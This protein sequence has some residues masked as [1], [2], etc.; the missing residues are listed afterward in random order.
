MRSGIPLVVAAD[1]DRLEE[2][3]AWLPRRL[4]SRVVERLALSR[5]GSEAAAIDQARKHVAGT[6]DR[7]SAELTARLV[8]VLRPHGS[9]VFGQVATEQAVR[10][11]NA[12]TLVVADGRVDAGG[13]RWDARIELT[14]LARQQGI[15]VITSDSDELH[16]LGGVGCTLR[17]RSVGRAAMLPSGRIEL[18]A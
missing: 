1:G 2:L 13:S 6:R 17:R 11:G 4:K 7:E 5:C 3:V 12:D 16:Y 14:R 9:A 8:R 15:P 10:T 18:V